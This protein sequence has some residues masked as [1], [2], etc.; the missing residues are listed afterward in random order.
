MPNI[1]IHGFEDNKKVGRLCKLIDLC[2]QAIGFGNDAIK[3]V[4]FSATLSC[5]GAN[6][7]K[8]YLR[9][10]TSEPEHI[11][12]ILAGFQEYR[13]H[14]DVEVIPNM[15]FEANE[16]ASGAWRKKFDDKKL[17]GENVRVR[18]LTCLDG[19]SFY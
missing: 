17:S 5:D 9:I 16:I 19:K 15:F 10:L 1:G 8:P 4:F 7:F 11:Q 12:V 18:N 6:T 2:M 13:I 3:E 14:E